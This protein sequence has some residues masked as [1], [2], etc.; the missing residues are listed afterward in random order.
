M[1][2]R[3]SEALLAKA[4]EDGATIR[5]AV[6]VDAA[7]DYM[8]FLRLSDRPGYLCVAKRRP[9]DGPKAWN[10]F[11]TLQRMLH[12]QGYRGAVCVFPE[13]SPFPGRLGISLGTPV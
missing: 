13:G 6:V 10:D 7:G 2:G 5:R 8:L 11:R 9:I 1:Q 4:L 3:L 12:K